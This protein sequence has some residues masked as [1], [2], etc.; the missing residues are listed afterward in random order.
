MIEILI[1]LFEKILKKEDKFIL[2]KSH[3]ISTNH[4][5][6]DKGI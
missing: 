5:F 6:K 1:S 4:L 2:S 3:V